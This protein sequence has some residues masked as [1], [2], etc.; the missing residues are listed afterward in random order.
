MKFVESFL[1]VIIYTK[2]AI[3]PSKK[4]FNVSVIKQQKILGVTS[5]DESHVSNSKQI[6]S[7]I[8][9][10]LYLR[11]EF[12]GRRVKRISEGFDAVTQ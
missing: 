12:D 9:F 7:M 3:F 10:V 2:E 1:I 4:I 6:N 5:Y 11:E 8:L